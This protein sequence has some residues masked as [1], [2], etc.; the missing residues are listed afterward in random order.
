MPIPSK[1][2]MRARRQARREK[3]CVHF[4]GI[5]HQACLKGVKY[6]QRT[7]VDGKPHALGYPCCPPYP[8]DKREPFACE[9]FQPKNPEQIA[10]EEAEIEAALTRMRLVMPL[11]SEWRKK[12]PIGKTEVVRCPVC[13]GQ[14]QL[15]QSAFNGHVWG[16]C[17][18]ADCVNWME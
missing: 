4:N 3:T 7:M 1:D 5:Q 12:P 18:T 15:Q 10:A 11:V 14:L 16:R 6:H 9:H 17:S 2:E 13:G 8:T